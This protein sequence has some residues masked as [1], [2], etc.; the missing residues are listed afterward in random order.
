ME[1]RKA[2]GLPIGNGSVFGSGKSNMIR[3]KSANN[4]TGMNMSPG[5][6][7]LVALKL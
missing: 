5:K 2:A 7:K 3:S 6:Q 4:A 1:K